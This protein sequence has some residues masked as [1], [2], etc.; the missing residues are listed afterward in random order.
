MISDQGEDLLSLNGNDL[1]LF[2]RVVFSNRRKKSQRKSASL[3]TET[4]TARFLKTHHTI[5]TLSFNWQIYF[6]WLSSSDLGNLVL[7]WIRIYFLLKTSL[8]IARPIF[9]M[10]RCW[11]WTLDQKLDLYV[12]C[13]CFRASVFFNQ[14]INASRVADV[15]QAIFT[16][17]SSQCT[18]TKSTE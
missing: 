2:W 11:Q 12:P 16:F 8:W 1:A 17:L 4:G 18:G 3:Q 15:V 10:A 7:R 14:A 9:P 5:G 6:L 13:A